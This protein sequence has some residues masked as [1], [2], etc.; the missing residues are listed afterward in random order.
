[1]WSNYFR[2]VYTT[3]F[4]SIFAEMAV[5]SNVFSENIVDITQEAEGSGHP[6]P[7]NEAHYSILRHFE[8]VK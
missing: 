4:T 5:S 8:G 6:L 1:M 3:L 2:F 7:V